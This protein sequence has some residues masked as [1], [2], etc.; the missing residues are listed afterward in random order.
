MF[1]CFIWEEIWSGQDV[2]IKVGL[3]LFNYHNRCAKSDY[4]VSVSD[5]QLL[6]FCL[7]LLFKKKN[8]LPLYLFLLCT[9]FFSLLLL[10]LFHS[11]Y[12]MLLGW[13]ESPGYPNGYL[14]HA[15]LNWSR[16]APKGHSLSI[17]F[18]HLDLEDSIDCEND[19]VKVRGYL[20]WC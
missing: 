6:N 4:R 16:C 5:I 10:P 18:I 3:D 1:K 15:S 9:I 12:C 7:T 19:A 8:S 20:K 14:P 11:T 17:R 2:K 13:V